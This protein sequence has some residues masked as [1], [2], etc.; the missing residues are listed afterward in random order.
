MADNDKNGSANEEASDLFGEEASDL[1]GEETIDDNDKNGDVEY[2]KKDKV[3]TIKQKKEDSHFTIGIIGGQSS[4]KTAY[5]YTLGLLKMRRINL[6]G[7]HIGGF[8]KQ[9]SEFFGLVDTE[10]FKRDFQRTAIDKFDIFNMFPIQ[11]DKLEINIKAFD[12]AGEN[13]VAAIVP[14]EFNKIPKDTDRYKIVNDLQEKIVECNAF[15]FL[16][17]GELSNPRYEEELIEAKPDALLPGQILLH[18]TN[19]LRNEL[20]IPTT[21]KIQNPID[22]VLTKADTL[23]DNE[24]IPLEYFNAIKSSGSLGGIESINPQYKE[25]IDKLEQDEA[26]RYIK[27]FFTDLYNVT[28]IEFEN[29]NFHAIS[30]WGHEPVY[31]YRPD[32]KNPKEI[33]EI[34]RSELKEIARKGYTASVW[35]KDIQPVN[36]EK[37]LISVLEKTKIKITYSKR[38]KLKKNILSA[39]LII[40]LLIVYPFLTA[41]FGLISEK[42][43]LPKVATGFYFISKSNPF[44]KNISLQ[45]WLGKRYQ[46]IADVYL[47]GELKDDAYKTMSI[48]HKIL[49]KNLDNKPKYTK[50]NLSATKL[51]MKISSKYIMDKNYDKGGNCLVFAEQLSENDY[52]LMEAIVSLKIEIS[53]SYAQNRAWEKSFN[54]ILPLF[55]KTIN[56]SD[57]SR[58]LEHD[59]RAQTASSL[60]ALINSLIKDNKYEI[61]LKRSNFA[62]KNTQ[63]L[64]I[65]YQDIQ[66]NLSICYLNIG[67]KLLSENNV[68][69]GAQNI[70][71]AAEWT[72][73]GKSSRLKEILAVI[74]YNM[75]KIAFDILLDLTRDIY[76]HTTSSSDIKQYAI[77]NLVGYAKKTLNNNMTEGVSRLHLIY[78]EFPEYQVKA[79]VISCIN[80]A[81]IGLINEEKLNLYRLAREYI[82]DFK[83]WIDIE[84]D[85][86][87]TVANKLFL[88]GKPQKVKNLLEER[89]WLKKDNR[90]RKYI[91]HATKSSKMAFISGHSNMSSFYIDRHE[92]TNRSYQAKA[93]GNQ[94]IVPSFWGRDQYKRVSSKDNSPVIY[95]SYKQ[96]RK[97][98]TLVGKR[99]PSVKEWERAWGERNY[100]WGSNFAKTKSNTRESKNGCAIEVNLYQMKKDKSP[101]GVTGLAGNVAEYTNTTMI[102]EAGRVRAIVKGGSYIDYGK[103]ISVHSTRRVVENVKSPDVGFRCALNTL[104]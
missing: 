77:A 100:P 21:S 42:T 76:Y 52:K 80:E 97:Y 68:D 65:N 25:D 63:A 4:G 95:V 59:I 13:V 30:C 81:A 72:P 2:K 28:K 18:L 43:K 94:E 87:F 62:L 99:L 1:F 22:F 16:I 55:N 93:N 92:V 89:D 12:A 15:I 48:V 41:L 10:E 7:W 86:V 46:N 84:K 83:E 88:K 58:Q 24:F 103:N 36:I 27:H 33:V 91:K 69:D 90:Y 102:D 6:K 57:I 85:I 40:T 64:G 17:D 23:A 70:R 53:K 96:A 79:K 31:Y 50:L 67:E 3:E 82:G 54:Y 37:P 75:N 78:K 61:A 56:K 19:L 47:H 32:A 8:S 9:Y 51:W 45:M 11:K 14:H 39:A 74:K 44:F 20:K 35:V 49:M 5:L 38:K 104:P 66:D 73:T 26:E 98:A 71:R 60:S 29:K 34:Q 101:F